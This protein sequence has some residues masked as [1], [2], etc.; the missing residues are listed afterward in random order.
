MLAVVLLGPAPAF[1]IAAVSLPIVGL[2]A[3]TPW[4]DVVANY[5]NYGTHLVGQGLLAQWA[6]DAWN[7]TPGDPLLPLLVIG[8]YQF[9]V[10]ASY[11]YNGAYGALA[12]GESV[13]DNIRH[14]WRLQLATETP[15][16]VATGLTAYIYGTAGTGALLVLV[17]LQLIFVFLA[18]E[19]RLSQQRAE[20]LNVR[21]EELLRVHD[22]LAAHAT[23]ISIFG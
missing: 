21:T 1:A 10:G 19:L 8:I 12:Y 16:A 3:R 6:I 2:R 18:R 5:A 14:E 15:I 13:L 23:R 17:A 20:I 22:D 9:G 4:R 11:F 7:L